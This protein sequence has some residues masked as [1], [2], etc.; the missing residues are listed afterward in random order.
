MYIFNKKTGKLLNLD[1]VTEV[2]V[3]REGNKLTIARENGAM[4][5]FADYNTEAEAREAISMLVEFMNTGK[6]EVFTLPDEEEIKVRIR[7]KKESW[8]HATGKKTKGHG[9]S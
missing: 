4:G 5:I 7:N 3:G 1:K 2:L 8:H 6:R 9:G